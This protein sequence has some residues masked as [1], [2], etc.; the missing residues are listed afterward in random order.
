MMS[1]GSMYFIS[2]VIVESTGAPAFTRMITRLRRTT[3][4]RTLDE[5][6]IFK[7]KHLGFSSEATNFSMD[8]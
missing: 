3:S 2:S 7:R 1:S 6:S 5:C 8:S 4:K